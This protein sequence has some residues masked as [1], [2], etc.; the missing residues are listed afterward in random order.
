MTNFHQGSPH[1]NPVWIDQVPG[2]R[3]EDVGTAGGPPDES[4]PVDPDPPSPPVIPDPSTA[5][6]VFDEDAIVD[7]AAV[8]AAYKAPL[9]TAIQRINGLIGYSQAQIN[10]LKTTYTG[11]GDEWNGSRLHDTAVNVS[12]NG[13]VVAINKVHY[14]EQAVDAPHTVAFAARVLPQQGGDNQLSQSFILGINTLVVKTDAEWAQTFAHELCHALGMGSSWPRKYVDTANSRL[15]DGFPKAVEAY[16]TLVSSTQSSVLL[17]ATGGAGTANSHW[18]NSLRDNVPGFRNEIMIGINVPA[19]AVFSSLTLQ[20]LA[21]Q[22]YIVTG[23]AEGVPD[24]VRV[25]TT[26]DSMEICP[27]IE[28]IYDND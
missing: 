9:R 22:G 3:P 14:F 26:S 12:F 8:R 1:Y 7:D 15:I 16:R 27:A 2:Y 28:I 17:E 19:D 18:E 5:F 4:Q 24:L 23:N 13:G 11:G 20:C 6:S 21:D 25:R 10:T